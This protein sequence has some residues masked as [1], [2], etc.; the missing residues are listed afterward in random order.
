MRQLRKITF[1]N[2]VSKHFEHSLKNMVSLKILENYRPVFNLR[3]FYLGSMFHRLAEN[4]LIN[5]M[6]SA[7]RFL[8]STET[9]FISV[10]NEGSTVVP[11]IVL[12]HLKLLSIRSCCRV[13][14]TRTVLEAMHIVGSYLSDI[15]KCVNINGVLPNLKILSFGA[16]QGSVLGHTLHCLYKFLTLF[17]VSYNFY[18]D[19]T[20][21]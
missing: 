15:I 6:Q 21:L 9:N 19:E 5:I 12:L 11:L 10:L 1:K 16:P 7:Y 20:Q 18:A 14:T 8:H 4:N 13:Y 3:F 17:V 2:H